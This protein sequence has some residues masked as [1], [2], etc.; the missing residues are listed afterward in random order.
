MRKSLVYMCNNGNL[1]NDILKIVMTFFRR[2]SIAASR[3]QIFFSSFL[4]SPPKS[5]GGGLIGKSFH[6]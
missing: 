1:W 3:N 2:L 4:A 5:P 6:M